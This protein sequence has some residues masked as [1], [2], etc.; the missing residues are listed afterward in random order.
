ME[1]IASKKIVIAT[2]NGFLPQGNYGTN[3]Y[4]KHLSGWEVEEMQK[5]GFKVLG[6]YGYKSLRGETHN[7]R[8]KPKIFWGVV[9]LLSHYFYTRSHPEQAAAILC[10]KEIIK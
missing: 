10:I 2:P 8:Y 1:R 4:Q 9:S 3:E 7:L 5:L 6:V